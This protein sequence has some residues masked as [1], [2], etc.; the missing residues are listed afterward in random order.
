MSG[1]WQ[2]RPCF[3]MNRCIAGV[4]TDV[5]EA[6]AAG[7]CPGKAVVSPF[8]E[9]WVAR[10]VGSGGSFAVYQQPLLLPIHLVLLF[11]G[12]VV[13]YIIHLI[14]AQLQCHTNMIS[15]VMDSNRIWT[16]SSDMRD[17]GCRAHEH[18]W[19]VKSLHNRC[20]TDVRL[21]HIPGRFVEGLLEG[22]SHFCSY[23]RSVGK[24]KVGGCSHG[25][26]VALPLRAL[27][28]HARQLAVNQLDLA[29]SQSTVGR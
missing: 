15:F 3:W 14:H 26:Q 10:R 17:Q 27:N 6:F 16:L 18:S 25:L 8:R 29:A 7:S 24:G 21:T 11:L 20:S 9:R 12:C 19:H 22:A 5:A 23:E 4:C 1:K 13:C 2:K 28:G